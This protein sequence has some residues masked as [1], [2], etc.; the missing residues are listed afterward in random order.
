LHPEDILPMDRDI[1]SGHVPSTESGFNGRDPFNLLTTK[2]TP[3]PTEPAKPASMNLKTIKKEC[4]RMAVVM[5]VDDAYKRVVV[6]EC[7]VYVS[8]L[9][10]ANGEIT[11]LDYVTIVEKTIN[12]IEDSI[13]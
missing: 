6:K 9:Y 7:I 3:A 10:S 11:N 8:S 1:L 12:S 13:E 2:I 4:D 5:K